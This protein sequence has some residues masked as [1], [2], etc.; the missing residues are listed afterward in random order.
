MSNKELCYDVIGKI[1]EYIELKD[2]LDYMTLN[3]Q[4]Y[5]N[6]CEGYYKIF[7]RVMLEFHKNIKEDDV[8]YDK[9]INFITCAEIS[10][11]WRTLTT[12]NEYYFCYDMPN[13][14]YILLN[15]CRGEFWDYSE[16]TFDFS[17]CY[18]LELVTIY[19]YQSKIYDHNIKYKDNK[20]IVELD[21]QSCCKTRSTYY[22]A[23]DRKICTLIFI[24]PDDEYELEVY[25]N[26]EEHEEWI[27]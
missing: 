10:G 23:D 24:G 20:S 13:I 8:P 25:H 17:E 16:K 1:I 19:N 4:I 12:T 2:V 21:L 18:N 5:E 26:E 22:L 11:R 7:D 3:K 6:F 14:T 9:M 27:D 15:L